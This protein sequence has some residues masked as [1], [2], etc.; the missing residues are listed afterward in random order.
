MFPKTQGKQLKP[1]IRTSL[2]DEIVD[3][4]IDLIS[5]GILKPGERIPP[6]RELCKTFGVGR[7]SLREALRSLAI[8]GI[9]EGRVGEGTFICNSK[10]HLEKILKWGLLLDHKAVQDLI[11]TRL[12]LEKQTASLAAH[13]ASF[14]N[15]EEIDQTLKGMKASINQPEKYLEF[16]LRFHLLIALSTQNSILYSLLSLTRG[17][18]QEWITSSLAEPSTPEQTARA[19]LSLRQ[20]ER[21]LKA[22]KK[23]NAEDAQKTMVEHIL[24]S[25]LD[26]QAHIRH[27]SEG[28]PISPIRI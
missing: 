16:D 3:Q 27:R 10:K 9:L 1:V 17:Y 8:M 21:I 13:R 19:T 20:H 22:L 26:F 14:E 2:S 12:M 28:N 24:S 4:I 25:S 11:E 5:Q 6:E 15:L 7:T 23:N 18:L